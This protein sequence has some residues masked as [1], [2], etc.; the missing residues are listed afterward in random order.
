MNPVR[1]A[2]HAVFS[3]SPEKFFRVPTERE[4]LRREG[5]GTSTLRYPV[6]HLLVVDVLCL[7]FWTQ[8]ACIVPKQNTRNIYH[9]QMNNSVDSMMTHY[10]TSHYFPWQRV[11]RAFDIWSTLAK[12]SFIYPCYEWYDPSC[13]ASMTRSWYDCSTCKIKHKV[14]SNDKWHLNNWYSDCQTIIIYT[15]KPNTKNS[16]VK[17]FQ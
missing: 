10:V 6:I 14:T 7:W 16:T 1:L 12:I 2:W 15:I 9:K 8:S 17:L 11:S 4:R 3:R 5:E 13:K